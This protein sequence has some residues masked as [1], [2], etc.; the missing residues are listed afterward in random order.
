MSAELMENALLQLDLYDVVIGPAKD[1]GYYL[2]GMSKPMNHIF[3]NKKWSTSSVLQDTLAELMDQNVYLLK[4]LND[5]DTM[6][7]L[8]T[9]S[10]CFSKIMN[11]EPK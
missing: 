10:V 11:E 8:K 9:S 5:I 7:D 6:E 3:E 2:M 1:G 4:E